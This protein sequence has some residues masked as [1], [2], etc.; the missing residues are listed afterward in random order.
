MM[1]TSSSD[2]NPDPRVTLD[3]PVLIH[4]VTES[5]CCN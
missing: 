3:V 4:P 1:A 2:W 5:Q